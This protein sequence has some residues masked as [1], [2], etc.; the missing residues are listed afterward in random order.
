LRIT[1]TVFFVPQLIRKVEQLRLEED[2]AQRVL[3]RLHRG[4]G[5]Q[6]VLTNDLLHASDGVR[7]VAPVPQDLGNLVRMLLLQ[8]CPPP[9]IARTTIGI[10]RTRDRPAAKVMRPSGEQLLIGG[11]RV[12]AA[13]PLRH[14]LGVGLLLG[15]G[16]ARMTIVSGSSAF[17]ASMAEM[18]SSSCAGLIRRRAG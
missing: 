18:A 13:H 16:L 10:R 4:I 7:P 1:S 12:K 9:Q 11:A 8:R 14:H 5:R 2:E 3:M 15:P 6:S 17:A